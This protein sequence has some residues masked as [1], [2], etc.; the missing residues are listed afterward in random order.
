MILFGQKLEANQVGHKSISNNIT[1]KKNS[2][3]LVL[4]LYKKKKKKKK[5]S[6]QKKID[7]QNKKSKETSSLS[8]GCLGYMYTPLLGL[9]TCATYERSV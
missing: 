7:L 5:N 3:N 2:Q 4:Q 6:S 9:L 8:S 1:K